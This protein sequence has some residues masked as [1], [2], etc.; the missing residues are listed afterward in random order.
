VRFEL[1]SVKDLGKLLD[2]DD[3]GLREIIHEILIFLSNYWL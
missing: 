2:V 3:V 1:V